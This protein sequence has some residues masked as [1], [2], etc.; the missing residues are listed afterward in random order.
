MGPREERPS[1]LYFLSDNGEY[2]RIGK[3]EDVT[4]QRDG[5]EE[6]GT[7][8]YITRFADGEVTGTVKIPRCHSQ[9]RYV[10]LLM[11]SGK[12]RDFANRQ[13]NIV[14]ARG[15][16]WKNAWAKWIYYHTCAQITA[17]IF[18]SLYPKLLP[19]EERE[20]KCLQ[21]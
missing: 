10:K 6:K 7:L 5:T 20:I 19:K 14:H 9:K 8:E 16:S 13:A 12:S 17:E 21:E 4:F 11:A 1:I 2:Q 3:L 18:A 15:D